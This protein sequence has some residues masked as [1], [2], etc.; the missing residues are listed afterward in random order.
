MSRYLIITYVT[1][2]SGQ[3]DEMM[4][5]AKNLKLKDV[6][7]GSVILDFKRLEV[8]TASLRG[9]S[10]PKDWDKIV[11]YY[12]QYYEATIERLFHENGWQIVKPEKETASESED[13]PA[14]ESDTAEDQSA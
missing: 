3:I 1:K 11:S 12:N 8:V 2:P 6:Q 13:A 10:V 7:T 14:A 4:T 9:E 5:I